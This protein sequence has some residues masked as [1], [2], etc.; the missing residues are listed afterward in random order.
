MYN[1]KAMSEALTDGIRIRV[2]PRYLPEHSNPISSRWLFGYQVAISNEG[3]EPV[4]LVTRHWIIT[5]AF[6]ETEEVEGVGVVGETPVIEPG[7]TYRYASFCPL[8]TPFG[9]MH[10]SY[11]MVRPSGESF[12]ATVE[13][14]NLVTPDAVN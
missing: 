11:G 5:D 4:R 12:Q 10:G 6:G 9:S 7:E 3:T 13:T 2:H 14:F 8:K 1:M